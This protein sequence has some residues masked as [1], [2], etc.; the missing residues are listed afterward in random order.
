MGRK[1]GSGS[2]FQPSG[3]RISQ[4]QFN[5]NFTNN[6]IT[7]NK[8]TGLDDV[9]SILR[10][11]NANNGN[12]VASG[13]AGPVMAGLLQNLVQG[14]GKAGSPQI[15]PFNQLTSDLNAF[16][17]ARPELSISNTGYIAPEQQSF[18]PLNFTQSNFSGNSSEAASSNPSIG[19][20]ING[21]IPAPVSN[22]PLF[23]AFEQQNTTKNSDRNLNNIGSF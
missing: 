11:N 19:G 22:N 23:N 21:P 18:K 9:N 6:P 3:N 14:S 15:N 4:E 5:T 7:T 12:Y 2:V 16:Q 10:H 20:A 8:L 1:N 13:S 17:P